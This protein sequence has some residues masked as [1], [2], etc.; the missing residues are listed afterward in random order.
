LSTEPLRWLTGRLVAGIDDPKKRD[1]LY[2][3]AFSWVYGSPEENIDI[4]ES[5]YHLADATL[6]VSAL[7][8]QIGTSRHR[9]LEKRLTL[10]LLPAIGSPD[11]DIHAVSFEG[12]RQFFAL[13]TRLRHMLRAYRN[14]DHL[15]RLPQERPP[16]CHRDGGLGAAV[17][18][19]RDD[20][21]QGRQAALWH[22]HHWAAALEQRVF[23]GGL[24][25]RGELFRLLDEDQIV[26]PAA[27]PDDGVL[28]AMERARA[29]ARDPYAP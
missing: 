19:D 1:A 25:D 29:L 17:P 8:Q 20:L 6:R 10:G 7:Q 9:F 26:N 21:A 13:R 24:G 27:H 4:F 15:A 14:D 12:A 5:L 23:E 2:E 28:A 3:L 16:H 11:A 18:R 22:H